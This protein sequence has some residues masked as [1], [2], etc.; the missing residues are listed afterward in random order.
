MATPKKS[1]VTE[2]I[3]VEVVKKN[4]GVKAPSLRYSTAVPTDNQFSGTAR[5]IQCF[6][7]NGFPNFRIVTLTL[8]KGKV[9]STHYS[10]A[11]ASFEL[12][13]KLNLANDIAGISLS[14][15][16]EELKAMSK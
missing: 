8:E 13:A 9:A 3:P 6:W 2:S 16:W 15:H 12:G 4:T 10:D 1:T 11:Y 14:L 7:N 5:S